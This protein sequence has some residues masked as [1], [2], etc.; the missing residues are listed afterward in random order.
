MMEEFQAFQ[1]IK[2]KRAELKSMIQL[3]ADF[4]WG[5]YVA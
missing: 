3:Y 5:E 4:T 2:R 1:D